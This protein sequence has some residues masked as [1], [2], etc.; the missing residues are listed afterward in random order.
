M[1]NLVLIF[2]G[3]GAGSV[4]RFLISS[5]LNGLIAFP[6]GTFVVNITGSLLLGFLLG[7]GLREISSQLSLLL[8]IGFCGGFTTFST[9]SAETLELLKAGEYLSLI[10]YS[11]L[12]LACGIIAV[13]AGIFLSRLI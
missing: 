13:F 3:G 1:K 7:L 9:F 8:M 12:S 11:G 4:F 6:L 5:S 10:L 2:L